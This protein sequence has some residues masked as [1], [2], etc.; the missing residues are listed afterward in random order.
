MH[1]LY[2]RMDSQNMNKL[3]FPEIG[4]VHFTFSSVTSVYYNLPCHAPK[5]E[6]L[7]ILCKILKVTMYLHRE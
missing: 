2:Q 3:M 4:R 6:F 5:F 1:G 7:T